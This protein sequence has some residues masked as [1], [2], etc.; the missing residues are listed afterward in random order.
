MNLLGLLLC[1]ATLM[2]DVPKLTYIKSFPGS[3]PAYVQITVD[4]TG[5][6]EYREAVDDD[7]PLRFQLANAEV[8]ELFG[9]TEKL[10]HFKRELESGLKVANMGEKTFRYENG[11]EKHETKFNFT[12]DLDGRALH[13][14]FERMTET[15]YHLI[16]LQ[17]VVRFDKLGLNNA[18]LQL[19]SSYDRKRLVAAEQFLPLLDRVAKN[20]TFMHMSRERAASLADAIRAA[21]PKGE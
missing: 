13:E 10:D 5:K 17:R 19:Q 14:W 6:A 4:N 12:Q 9:Y 21:K 11:A 18:L 8:K 3:V 15:E 7:S 20:E 1:A 16:V 2:A